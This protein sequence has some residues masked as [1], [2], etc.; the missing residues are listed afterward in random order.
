M[1]SLE[2]SVRRAV[3]KE[4]AHTPSRAEGP[5]STKHQDHG[6]SPEAPS[7]PRPPATTTRPLREPATKSARRFLRK[8]ERSVFNHP[9][10]GRVTA[11][12][13]ENQM[14]PQDPQYTPSP[15]QLSP[16][17]TVPAPS[18]L[19]AQDVHEVLLSPSVASI[20]SHVCSG[21]GTTVPTASNLFPLCSRR[22][23]AGENL[24]RGCEHRGQDPSVPPRLK[25]GEP[26]SPGPPAWCKKRQ[27]VG[28]T[29][30]QT[31]DSQ[32]GAS[33]R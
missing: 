10:T 31:T 24:T 11:R 14:P 22:L 27:Q 4:P 19:R 15:N 8:K 12:E 25:T 30:T 33:C 26:P 17:G 1:N 18:A 13:G 9:P 2:Q 21:L 7:L 3:C 23:E 28:K 20:L 32:G 6:P 5:P 29:L 16:L